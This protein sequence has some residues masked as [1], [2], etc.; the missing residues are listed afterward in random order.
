M[1]AFA[2]FLAFALKATVCTPVQAVASAALNKR[3]CESGPFSSAIHTKDLLFHCS[4]IEPPSFDDALLHLANNEA[5][6]DASTF[7]AQGARVCSS[8]G[9]NDNPCQATQASLGVSASVVGEAFIKVAQVVH[10]Q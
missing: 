10:L 3:G 9:R 5:V 6:L 8:E 4:A 2:A 1:C 7:I